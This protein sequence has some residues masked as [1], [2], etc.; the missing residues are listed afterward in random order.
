MSPRAAT[1]YVVRT[2]CLLL[3]LLSFAVSNLLT[4]G[5]AVTLVPDLVH[6]RFHGSASAL[7]AL[8]ATGT[9]CALALAIG[10]G[11]LGRTTITEPLAG[12]CF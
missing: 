10:A 6:T 5:P 11:M 4:A 2:R 9:T 1:R 8:L 12:P 7:G 3:V